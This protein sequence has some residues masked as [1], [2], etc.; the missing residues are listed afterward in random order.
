MFHN[1]GALRQGCSLLAVLCGR[2]SERKHSEEISGDGLVYQF[3]EL[4]SSGRLEVQI[5]CLLADTELP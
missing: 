2:K 4:V 1:Q 3:P 5:E